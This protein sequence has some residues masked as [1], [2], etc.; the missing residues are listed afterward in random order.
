MD[1]SPSI[2][3]PVCLRETTAARSGRC[4]S[5][6]NRVYW[7]Y[8]PCLRW[9]GATW[10][11][12]TDVTSRSRRV[13]FIENLGDDVAFNTRSRVHL[14]ADFYCKRNV[15]SK[16]GKVQMRT[17]VWKVYVLCFQ[18]LVLHLLLL[19]LL[20]WSTC[21]LTAGH[22]RKGNKSVQLPTHSNYSANSMSVE[23]CYSSLRKSLK[24]LPAASR[25]TLA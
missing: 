22:V 25:T 23:C 24:E 19:F 7:Q 15:R 1:S 13:V 9:A 17:D 8:K 21:F 3:R 5:V 11:S 2:K 18:L 14:S 12:R 16:V 20:L 4:S 10:S 6:K